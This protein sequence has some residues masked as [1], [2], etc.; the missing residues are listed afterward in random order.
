MRQEP[1][2]PPVDRLA[3]AGDPQLRRVLL[4]ARAR[5][6]PFTA[7]DVALALDVH[8]NVARRRL[9]RLA[10]AGFL[11]V[12]RERREGRRGP[13]AGRPAKKIVPVI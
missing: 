13:G 3:A 5:R 11:V 7:A 9:D 10:E 12:T 2:V 4:F 1:T 6:S 8:H